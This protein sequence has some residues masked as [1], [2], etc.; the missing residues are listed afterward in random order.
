M[1]KIVL[2][3]F[4]LFTVQIF[5]QFNNQRRLK[6]GEDH[7]RKF[8]FTQIILIPG[9][10]QSAAYYLYKIPYQNL[11]F[12]KNGSKY[13]SEVRLAIEVKNLNSE[14]VK[15]EIKD[16]KIQASSFDETNSSILFAEGFIR[17]DLPYGSFNILPVLTDLNSN[18]EFKI[19]KS[20]LDI[21]I[22]NPHYLKPFIVESKKTLCGENELFQVTNFEGNLPFAT[23]NYNFIIPVS[24]IS[25]KEINVTVLSNSDT[26]SKTTLK[27]FFSGSLI[28]KECS[29]KITVSTENDNSLNNFILEGI[30]GKLKEGTFTIIVNED[31][32]SSYTGDVFWYNKPLSLRNPEFAIKALKYASEKQVV[33]SLLDHKEKDYYK[34]LVEY[35]KKMDPSP[36][37][38][39]NEL[40]A[41]YYS[42]VDYAHLNFSSITGLR[43]VD[44]DRGMIYIKFGKPDRVERSS[45]VNGKVV[46]TWIYTRPQQKFIFVDKQGMGE[47]SLESS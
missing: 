1:K 14:F 17:L 26:I 27:D 43:G 40:M 42:R 24:D 5:S 34:A 11:V 30:S 18:R 36:E 16:W 28:L 41:E 20:N 19:G 6:P 13:I 29:G 21:S 2:F 12:L 32:A 7:L 33:D 15:R 22:E 44:T 10:S 23:E 39:F 38:E 31:T 37:L 35:W 45:N 25:L 4:I 8:V 3:L 46:E 9:S 47:F